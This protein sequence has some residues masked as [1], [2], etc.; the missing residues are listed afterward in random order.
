MLVRGE[1]QPVTNTEPEPRHELH[2]STTVIVSPNHPT[3]EQEFEAMKQNPP[4]GT[5]FAI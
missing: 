1:D 3:N 5:N 2:E 4:E